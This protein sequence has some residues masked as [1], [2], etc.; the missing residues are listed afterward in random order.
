MILINFM[1]KTKPI[2]LKKI[3]NS[4]RKHIFNTIKT[5][6]KQKLIKQVKSV[7]WTRSLFNIG[8]F[9]TEL[10]ISVS[11]LSVPALTCNRIQYFGNNSL[12]WTFVFVW[13]RRPSLKQNFLPHMTHSLILWMRSALQ[14]AARLA[15]NSFDN[16]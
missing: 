9:W 10:G 6:K 8:T 15:M 3:S 14:T 12:I 5:T 4:K 2:L 1:P 11:L 13:T 7:C 16:Q